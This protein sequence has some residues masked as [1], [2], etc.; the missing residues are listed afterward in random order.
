MEDDAIADDAVAAE[1][2]A[3]EADPVELAESERKKPSKK[4]LIIT[5][6]VG[7]IVMVGMFKLLLPQFGSYEQAFNKLGEMPAI[8]VGALVVA[9]LLNIFLYPLT[10]LVSVTG[11]R[12]WHGFVERQVGFL[13]S[14]S[15]PGGGAFAVGAQYRVLSLYRVPPAVSASAVS[16]DAVWTF[17][18]TLGMPAIGVGLLVI[19]GRSTAGLV[20]FAVIGMVAFI[21]MLA[22]SIVVIRSEPGARRVGQLG[23]KLVNPIFKKLKKDPPRLE[24]A[25]VEFRYHAHDLVVTRWRKLTLTNLIAQL[26]P[27]LI[28]VCA[29]GG[30]GEYPGSLTLVEIF[31]AY[32]V[33]LLLVSFPI[34]PGGLGTVD[35][36]LVAL[37]TA[38]GCPGDVA[39][40]ADLTWRL[41]WF[42]PQIIVG[43]ITMVVYLLSSH[44]QTAVPTA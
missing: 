6:V 16:A 5:A 42:L 14:N 34:T 18:L 37:L 38:F 15:I 23:Q 19:E 43:A 30:L 2:V 13:I 1:P 29:I 4:R 35:A 7:L 24:A 41:V 31:A 32:S 3:S 10:V 36:A 11:L 40:A 22:A 12:Y 26:T 33:A 17:L 9:C 28:L 44:R 25:L 27:Y 8:W 21:F 20:T 39:V